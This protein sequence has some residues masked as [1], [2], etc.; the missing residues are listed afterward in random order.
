MEVSMDKV[1]DN[2]W[3]DDIE[4][5]V[6]ESKQ[7]NK[8]VWERDGHHGTDDLQIILEFEKLGLEYKIYNYKG[9]FEDN[10][11]KIEFEYKG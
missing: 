1:V 6:E 7:G 8:I 3:Y 5:L 4:K 2:I 9:K 10:A 11:I